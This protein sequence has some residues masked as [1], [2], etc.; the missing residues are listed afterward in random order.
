MV[1]NQIS[2]A[3][4][5]QGGKPF[6]GGNY[7]RK[8]SISFYKKLKNNLPLQARHSILSNAG[9]RSRKITPATNPSW[10]PPKKKKN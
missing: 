6:K 9:K 8:Y 1:P 7:K 3:E 10:R 2:A 5:I 4:T